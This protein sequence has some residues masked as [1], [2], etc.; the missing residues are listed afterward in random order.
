MLSVA[1]LKV[2]CALGVLVHN[3]LLLIVWLLLLLCRQ[4]P[5][6]ASM[7]QQE[8]FV[9]DLLQLPGPALNLVLQQLDKCSLAC[10]AVTSRGLS[11]AVLAA[12]HKIEVR[13][14]DEDTFKS[15]RTW[16]GRNSSSLNSLT[17]LKL[18]RDPSIC[19]D[20]LMLRSLPCQGLRELQLTHFDVQ[21]EPADGYPG[22][23]HECSSLTALG[24]EHCSVGNADAA[25][26]ALKALPQLQSLGLVLNRY[27]AGIGP[28]FPVQLP[29]QLKQLGLWCIGCSAPQIAVL[30]QLSSLV[31]LQE[32]ALVMLPV[33]GIPGGVPSQLTKLTALHL[34][35]SHT[36][37][38]VPRTPGQTGPI[39]IQ[40]GSNIP[41]APEQLKHL[42]SLTA[43]QHL[44]FEEDHMVAD[45]LSG[46]QHLSQ[47][48]HLRLA[49]Y[50]LWLS[51][52]GTRSWACLSALQSLSLEKC[53]V[54]PGWLATLTQL[55]SLS[56]RKMKIGREGEYTELL[57]AVSALTLLT[58]LVF[59][60][61]YLERSSLPPAEAFTALTASTNLCSLQLL[62]DLEGCVIFE[63]GCLHP[64]LRVVNLHAVE[65]GVGP[66]MP[67]TVQQL[68]SMC[69]S[70]PSLCSLTF[71][72]PEPQGDL[73]PAAFVPL[74]QLSVLTALE[75]HNVGA[76]TAALVAVVAQLTGLKRLKLNGLSQLTDPALEP[77]ALLKGL[78]ELFLKGPEQW[79]SPQVTL[80]NNVSDTTVAV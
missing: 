36:A 47:L 78:E 77:L 56:L 20:E 41:E 34:Q 74:L 68:E 69:S 71:A 3:T 48:T 52:D 46:L 19:K 53:R 29:V 24:L 43:L 32:L 26:A 73:S 23:L 58:A 22:V 39:I 12:A 14:S 60:E 76:A 31:N 6:A 50:C 25:S 63:Q 28:L 80:R 10:T 17:E 18:E 42:S 16:I 7:S 27:S 67:A 70:C 37:P 59:V 72:L 54:Q 57:A 2:C 35:Y 9:F 44:A 75:V 15:I 51:S 62:M 49:S 33:G 61:G 8:P 13:C 30:S 66:V 79:R 40:A 5:P 1:C 65:F 64:D 38:F 11:N 4:V 55:Q 45:D 21:L